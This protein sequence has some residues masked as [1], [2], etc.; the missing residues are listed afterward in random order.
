MYNYWTLCLVVATTGSSSRRADSV[1]TII[2][3]KRIGRCLEGEYL[4][5]FGREEIG[6]RISRGF[7]AAI[8]KEFVSQNL[9]SLYLHNW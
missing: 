2:C 9:F 6:I 1:G 4:R 5:G 7:L 8:K 3:A